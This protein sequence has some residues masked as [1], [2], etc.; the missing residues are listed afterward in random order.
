MKIEIKE[1][2]NAN[3]I[4]ITT[5]DERWYQYPKTKEWFASSSWISSY[6]PSKELAVW[7][8]KRGFDEAQSIM[9]LRGEFGGRV[10]NGIEILG[11]DGE[12]FHNDLL[13]DAKGEIKEITAEEYEALITFKNWADTINPKFIS[14]EKTVFNSHYR[15]AGTLDCIAE[16]GGKIYI[17]DFKTSANIYLSHELQISSYFH[18]DDV[19]ADAMAILQVSY[20]KNKRGWKFTEIDDKFNLFLSAYSFWAEKNLNNQPHQKDYP[21]SIKLKA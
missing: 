8:A 21:K 19:K 20:N 4:R 9:E 5:T 17:I 13:P 16:I 10:H 18:A 1:L 15:Y 7:M 14:F 3:T 2:L 12:I 6:V 11:K